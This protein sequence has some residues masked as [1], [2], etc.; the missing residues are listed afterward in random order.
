MTPPTESFE[1]MAQRAEDELL[2]PSIPATRAALINVRLIRMWYSTEWTK[3]KESEEKFQQSIK[4]W[5]WGL[6][7]GIALMGTLGAMII[8][9]L[10]TINQVL[11]LVRHVS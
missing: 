10:A 4:R 9:A 8:W 11:Q 3:H 6:R 1:E 2:D 7:I 5:V